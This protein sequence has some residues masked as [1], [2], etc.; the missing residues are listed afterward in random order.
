MTNPLVF[1]SQEP[2][3][4]SFPPPTT[5]LGGSNVSEPPCA[6]ALGESTNTRAPVNTRPS[7]TIV[8]AWL[9]SISR[10]ESRYTALPRQRSDHGAAARVR[11]RLPFASRRARTKVTWRALDGEDVGAH[12]D[13]L[14]GTGRRR[15][16]GRQHRRGSAWTGTPWPPPP[17]PGRPARANHRHWLE[18]LF[19]LGLAGVFLTNA[20]V[21]LDAADELRHA[22]AAEPSGSVAP[23]RRC[24]VARAA[25]R[26]QRPAH[27]ARSARRDLVTARAHSLGPGVGRHSTTRWPCSS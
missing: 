8:G 22:G 15:Q 23:P 18:H 3:T 20:A 10:S 5:T 9:P 6:S 7:A 4:K 16:R 21:A 25:D 1:G 26:R 19:L 24:A 2:L 27:R 14:A 12:E 17:P 13:G 11:R